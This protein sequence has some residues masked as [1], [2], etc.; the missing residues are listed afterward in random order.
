[1]LLKSGPGAL[2]QLLPGVGRDSTAIVEIEILVS[3]AGKRSNKS[4]AARSRT[5]QDASWHE[6]ATSLHTSPMPRVMCTTLYVLR[7]SN[8]Q[9]GSWVSLRSCSSRQRP[10]ADSRPAAPAAPAHSS[11]KHLGRRC[12]A[13]RGWGVKRPEARPFSPLPLPCP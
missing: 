11:R 12:C 3:A 7:R 13:K 2:R 10:S 6:L 8:G 4:F 5:G 1:M 9:D